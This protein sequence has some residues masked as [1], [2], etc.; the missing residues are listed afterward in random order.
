MSARSGDFA[1]PA[2][3]SLH[4]R[5]AMEQRHLRPCECSPDARRPRGRGPIQRLES[6]VHIAQ[7][8]EDQRVNTRA[9]IALNIPSMRAGVN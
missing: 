4:A 7:A 3:K 6:A 8:R 5:V 9:A 2:A 1:N